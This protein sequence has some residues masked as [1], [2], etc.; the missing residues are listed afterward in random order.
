MIVKKMLKQ[1][2]IHKK[3]RISLTNNYLLVKT[4]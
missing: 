4:F 2:K 3:N 1:D